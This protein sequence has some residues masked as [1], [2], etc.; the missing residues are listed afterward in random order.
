MISENLE[1]FIDET[2]EKQFTLRQA[3][4]VVGADDVTRKAA[5]RMKIF[6]LV[7]DGVLKRHPWRRAAYV[8]SESIL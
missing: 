7:K 4:S 1:E 5:V 2:V 8:K 6:R 3:Y